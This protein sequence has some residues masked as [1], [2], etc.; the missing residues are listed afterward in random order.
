[1]R[2][3]VAAHHAGANQKPAQPHHPVQVGAT[4]RVVPTHPD[5][6]GVEPARRGG[7]PHRAQPPV[8]GADQIAQLMTH[9]RTRTARMLMGHQGIPH[10]ALRVALDPHQLKL[11]HRPDRARHIVG[12]HHWVREHPR[13]VSPGALSSGR[14]Q[15]DLA[16]CLEHVQR[17][18]AACAL[19]PP[20]PVAQVERLTDPV[21]DLPKARQ[22]FTAHAV[23]HTAKS[24]KIGPQAA[25]DLILNL[26]GAHGSAPAW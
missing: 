9:E 2:G 23:E 7:E 16:L 18:A 10:P 14:R 26:H 15:H 11:A 21:G 5:I 25:P 24:G 4:L 22:P 12:R 19:P 3:E 8:G 1:M 20:A 17:L 6:A 13:P